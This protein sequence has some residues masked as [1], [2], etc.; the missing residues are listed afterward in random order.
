[1]P[2]TGIPP[3]LIM[4]LLAWSQLMKGLA[5]WRAAKLS[6]RN[7]FV[8]ILIINTVGILELVYLFKFATKKLTI[9]EI[10]SWLQSGATSK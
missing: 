6:Q 5:M 8:A 3:L 2:E 4:V 1:M 10:K 9:K 7:W